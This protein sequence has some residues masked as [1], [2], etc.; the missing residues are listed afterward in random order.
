MSSRLERAVQWLDKRTNVPSLWKRATAIASAN[1]AEVHRTVGAMLL[2]LLAVELLTGVLLSFFYSPSAT[3]AWASVAY[4]E[5][6]VPLGSAL[7]GVH[8]WG[9]T[10]LM[11]LTIGHLCFNFALGLYRKPRE[12]NWWLGIAMLL[13]LLGFS[14]TGL[15][16]V[17]DQRGF[18]ASQ[19]ETQIMAGAPGGDLQR[20]LLIGANDYG[21]L[22][23]TRMYALHALVLPGALLGLLAIHYALAKRHRNNPETATGTI[24]LQIPTPARTQAVHSLLGAA[25]AVISL[26]ALAAIAGGAP[27]S[28]P[29]DPSQAF[30]ARPEWYFMPMYALRT[31]L[32]DSLEMLATIVLPGVIVGALVLV[33][34]VDRGPD[35]LRWKRIRFV[36]LGL[37]LL[38]FLG[39][40]GLGKWNDSQN[41]DH[42]KAVE[43]EAKRT[44]TAFAL[45]E[46]GKGAPLDPLKLSQND[47]VRWGKELFRAQ[48]ASCHS[49]GTGEG[50]G[51]DL[52]GWGGR[53]WLTRFLNDPNHPALYGKTKSLRCSMKPASEYGLSE[54]DTAAIVDALLLNRGPYTPTDLPPADKLSPAFKAAFEKGKCKSCHALSL[55]GENLGAKSGIGPD[56][57]EYGSPKWTERLL[58]FP[59]DAAHYG[60]KNAMPSFAESLDRAEREA[61]RTYLMTLHTSDLAPTPPKDQT[62]PKDRCE[63]APSNPPTDPTKTTDPLTKPPTPP[64]APSLADGQEVFDDNC[65]GC[66]ALAGVGGGEGPDLGGYFSEVW[67]TAFLKNPD[68]PNLYGNTKLKGQMKP[69]SA[70]DLADPDALKTVVAA[71]RLNR[72]LSQTPS[73]ADKK[74]LADFSEIFEDSSCGACH[75]ISINGQQ[76]GDP[77]GVG[78]HLSSYGSAA[79]LKALLSSPDA[80]SHYGDLNAMPPFQQLS[81][82]ELDSLTLYLL[83]LANSP[84]HPDLTK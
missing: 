28:S 62:A 17:Y 3:D 6:Q 43:R 63:A 41:A 46:Q 31:L 72:T 81:P 44:A 55:Q 2:G 11:A 66:H 36:S 7:R 33:P 23:L 15:T 69:A 80:P 42:Q 48:C 32:P 34:L 59:S 70:Y 79:W 53:A 20:A 68:H 73:D 58:L 22:T 82:H 1:P 52:G 49:V 25:I 29:A 39:L 67:L 83:D 27:F 84:T 74:T 14:I 18:W 30:D 75:M 60:S 13:M 54:Q 24:P 40:I 51:P 35:P 64:P 4:I 12:V 50:S 77:E 47:P 61:L 8:H 71:L 26:L 19:V 56:L 5:R 76:Q 38:G 21:N 57:S 9:M 65:S 10:A 45:L 37:G 78:P 16:L